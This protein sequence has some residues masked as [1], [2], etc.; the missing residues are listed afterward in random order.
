MRF[1]IARFPRGDDSWQTPRRGGVVGDAA[2]CWCSG[3]LGGSA[4]IGA[5]VTWVKKALTPKFG[6]TS[7]WPIMTRGWDPQ[8]TCPRNH[9]PGL[10][11][12]S[13]FNESSKIPWDPASSSPGTLGVCT[14]SL[15]TILIL[16]V[17]LGYD[18]HAFQK[19]PHD[20]LV[21][22]ILKRLS[23]GLYLPSRLRLVLQETWV[24]G[25]TRLNKRI[26]T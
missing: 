11:L 18:Q 13:A 22:M 2:R 10:S 8:Q 26:S 15:L 25:E 7:H 21:E 16:F 23:D 24:G 20:G 17:I 5:A 3:I 1:C 19:K 6:R 4:Q 12:S 14:S 9:P